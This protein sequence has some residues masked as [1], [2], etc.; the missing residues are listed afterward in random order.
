M[1]DQPDDDQMEFDPDYRGLRPNADRG[2]EPRIVAGQL[3][4]RMVSLAALVERVEAAF[5]DEY[6]LDSP[7]LLEADTAPKRVKLILETAEYV[8]SVESVSLSNEERA[9]V[10]S[11]AYSNLFSYG[12]LDAFFLDEAVTTIALDGPD[13][14]AVRYGPGELTPVGPLFQD[15]EQY[16]RIIRRMLLDAG[17]ELRPEQPIMEVGLVAGKRPVCL[18]LVAPPVT[19]QLTADIRVHPSLALSLDD[20]T[21]SGF[22]TG[23]AAALL[24][25]I[26]ASSHGVMVVGEPVS[27]KT[28]LL[29]ALARLLP[30]E[31]GVA[32][33]RAGELSLPDS[34]T[35]LMV[36][37]PVE[38]ESGITF[39]EQITRALETQPDYLLLDEIRADEPH[40]IAPLLETLDVPRQIW[41]FRGT[42]FAKRLQSA[43]S[44]LARRADF[45]GGE[46][47]V[48]ALY[49]RLPFVLSVLNYN[50]QLRLW[51]VAEWQFRDSPDYPTYV[52]LMHTEGGELKFTGERPARELSLPDRFWE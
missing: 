29:N 31:G 25:A 6:G 44:M 45:G 5:L 9:Q 14:A 10:I 37:W 52:L 15:R 50:G 47:L 12:P 1:P 11:S 33:Q 51:S 49:E 20:L 13:K 36:R 8:F 48:R 19:T 28:T 40:S 39:G 32:V 24:R 34:M 4:H 21:A 26:V 38:G 41:S 35:N 18:N 27:G 22:M 17:A 7:A 42:V 23:Q 3:G 2:R 46:E 30:G 43:L 16:E